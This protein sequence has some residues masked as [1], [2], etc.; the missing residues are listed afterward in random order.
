MKKIYVLIGRIQEILSSLNKVKNVDDI[1]SRIN[2]I[3]ELL[4]PLDT[5]F[6]SS[7]RERREYITYREINSL[8]EKYADK[9]KLERRGSVSLD[10][11]E[12]TISFKESHESKSE[13][14]WEVGSGSNWMGYHI[15]VFLALHEYLSHDNRQHFPP[16][17]FLVIDQPSQVYFPSTDSGEN[18]LDDEVMVNNDLQITRHND[19]LATRR[20]FEIL[21]SAIE[22]NNYNF[23]IIVLEHADKSI[24]GNIKD[25]DESACWKD[26]GDGL[27]PKN[28]I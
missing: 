26:V 22:N 16:F 11:K 14:L 17:S 19:I 27:I 6:K 15:S 12:L 23:Q 5:Y 24:W 7:D 28:W 3:N 21:S 8:I 9:F 4:I 20:I 13:Y 1:S 25:I 18:V 10:K 2:E